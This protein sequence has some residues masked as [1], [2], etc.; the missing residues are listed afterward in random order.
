MYKTIIL[1][2]ILSFTQLSFSQNKDT[3]Y[4]EYDSILKIK[5]EARKINSRI[6]SIMKYDSID[7]IKKDILIKHI[8]ITGILTHQTSGKRKITEN[9]Y[10]QL[11]Q[12]T[13]TTNEIY[14]HGGCIGRVKKWKK[15][16]F[17][18]EGYLITK[19]TRIYK[20]TKK[21]DKQNKLLKKEKERR[22]Y[23]IY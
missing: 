20:I 16:E 1:I 7:G 2:S 12:L 11:N 6:T 14:V 10:N 21:Y 13:S 5:T 9:T 18:N 3:I 8:G 19:L 4:V 17:T 22:V 15:I 23:A